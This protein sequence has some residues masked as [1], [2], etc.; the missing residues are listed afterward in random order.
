MSTRKR[1]PFRDMTP[2]KIYAEKLE[3][4]IDEAADN[5]VFIYVPEIECCCHGYH[6]APDVEV[7]RF[8]DYHTEYVDLSQK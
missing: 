5:G 2:Q 4:L 6:S 7:M 3:D 1:D 8:D